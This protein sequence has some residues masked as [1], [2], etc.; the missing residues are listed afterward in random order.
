MELIPVTKK[1]V[2]RCLK[3]YNW[4]PRILCDSMKPGV[5]N[6]EVTE[7]GG[8]PRDAKIVGAGYDYDRNLFF[9][10]VESE[11]FDEIVEGE[12][13]PTGDVTLTRIIR[14]GLSANK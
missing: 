8:I 6:Y 5:R 2:Q 14:E 12:V 3:R 7:D 4:D 1:N 10:I 9:V 13:I 11:S